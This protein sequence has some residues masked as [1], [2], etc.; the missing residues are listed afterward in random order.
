MYIYIVLCSPRY[1]PTFLTLVQFPQNK[2]YVVEKV[3]NKLL[4]ELYIKHTTQLA[5]AIGVARQGCSYRFWL[6]GGCNHEMRP[7]H[8]RLG[9]DQIAWTWNLVQ[10]SW[11][12]LKYYI[13]RQISV[14]LTHVQTFFM[15]LFTAIIFVRHKITHAYIQHSRSWNYKL[16]WT[17]PQ[18]KNQWILSGIRI[19][20]RLNHRLQKICWKFSE[21]DVA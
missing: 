5:I 8:H 2:L 7:I 4:K 9:L 12:S 11:S 15:R 18:G 14:R 3:A 20:R 13:A 19:T 6:G 10:S 1:G 21:T 16:T 17:L